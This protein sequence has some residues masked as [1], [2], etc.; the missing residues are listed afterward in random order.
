MKR[1]IIKIDEEKCNGCALCIVGCHEGALQIID[2]KARLINELFCDG[3]GACI[4]ECPEGAITIEHREAEE[5]SEV[6]TI[7]SLLGKSPATVIAHLEHLHKYKA[8]DFFNEGVAYLESIGENEIVEQLAER[9][10]NGKTNVTKYNIDKMNNNAH[11][12]NHDEGNGACGCPGSSARTFNTSAFPIA[13][14]PKANFTAPQNTVISSNTGRNNS[15]L[16]HWPVQLHLVPP[17]APFFRNSELVIM[18][19]CGGIAS[20]N[21]H[22]DYL[23]GRSVV[24]ACPKLD[25]TGPY[26]NK[27][28]SIFQNSNLKKAMVVRMEVPCCGGLTGIVKQARIES[29]IDDLIVEEHILSLQGELL[30]MNRC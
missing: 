24:I 7:K 12:H 19:S 15:G 21:I 30:S 4:G 13:E 3:L 17:N 14:S 28:A 18:N 6:E 9:I 11:H 23:A 26:V 16:S 27:L 25:K 5:Y 2:G 8:T 1:D 22:Q 20:A 29:G 10:M